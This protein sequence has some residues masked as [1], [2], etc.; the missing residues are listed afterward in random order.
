MP[1]TFV[2]P[3]ILMTAIL[4]S[5][6]EVR[7]EQSPLSLASN[8]DDENVKIRADEKRTVI[9][10]KSSSGIG[11]TTV[12]RKGKAWPP[13]VVLQ[14]HLKGLEGFRISNGTTV[15]EASVSKLNDKS[16]I[17]IWKDGREEEH[18]DPQSPFWMNICEIEIDNVDKANLLK[19]ECFEITLPVAFLSMNPK[20]ITLQWIDFYRN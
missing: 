18:L 1:K 13:R 10:V 12:E 8:P 9:S 7:P 5:A 17:R 20:S 14:M 3:L 2:V 11:K 15:L 4:S 6:A 16:R 19:A